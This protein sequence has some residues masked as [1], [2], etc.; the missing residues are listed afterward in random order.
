MPRSAKWEPTLQSTLCSGGIVQ[1]DTA[2]S[3]MGR[4]AGLLVITA[5]ALEA[6]D[7]RLDALCLQ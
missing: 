1:P 7:R 5:D 2:V 6:S 3:P 4:D